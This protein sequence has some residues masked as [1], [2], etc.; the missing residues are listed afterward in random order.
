[1]EFIDINTINTSNK[2]LRLDTNV[3][4]LMKSI[5]TVGLINPLVLNDNNELIAGGRRFSA[6]KALEMVEVPVVK[7]H[8]T[9]LEQELISIDE[10]LVRQD[11]TNIELEKS[12]SRGKE[13]YEDLY[14]TA[15]KFNDE[16]L[17]LP[18]DQEIKTDLPNNQRS[19]IDMTAEKTGLSKRVIKGA[20]ERE[21]RSSDSIK[22]LRS[23]GELNAT[24][25][26]EI[27]KLD[28]AHQET[29]ADH[30]SEKSA[31]EIK[32]FVQNIKA[33]GIDEAMDEFLHAPVMPKEYQSLKTLI[34]RVNKTLGKI[35]IEEVQSD[36]EEVSKLL[37]SISTLRMSLDQFLV[38]CAQ[39]IN[40]ET[41]QTETVQT[42][43]DDDYKDLVED[44]I[45]DLGTEPTEETHF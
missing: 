1:M 27:I 8:K 30:I 22:K 20:I 40:T 24:Q 5:E 36:H 29:I 41:A 38:L 11:L 16:D 6:M 34:K 3:D 31:K 26:N 23:H 44:A 35:L 32:N 19:F 21:E 17:T 42:I 33:N 39:D 4:K 15:T 12:L 43:G 7:V 45:T 10:N 14:P 2:Y 25:T 13:I 28:K 9:Q 37:D 18:Q